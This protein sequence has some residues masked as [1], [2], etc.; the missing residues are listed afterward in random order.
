MVKNYFQIRGLVAKL[1]VFEYSGMTFITLGKI[2][3]L[4]MKHGKVGYYHVTD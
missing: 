2:M 3:F 4:T 1:H